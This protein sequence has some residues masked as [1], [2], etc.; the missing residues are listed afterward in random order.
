MTEDGKVFIDICNLLTIN[1]VNYWACHGTLIGII[2]EN[3]L[4]PWDYVNVDGNS[5]KKVT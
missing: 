5:K 2:R 3:R 1:E 4:P